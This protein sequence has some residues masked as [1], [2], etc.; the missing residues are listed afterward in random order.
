MQIESY[1]YSCSSQFIDSIS[2][3]LHVELHEVISNLPKRNT[4]SEINQDLFWL[5]TSQGWSLK[6]YSIRTLRH[7]ILGFV[8]AGVNTKPLDMFRPSCWRVMNGVHPSI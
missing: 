1:Y 2:P 4:Q 6:G 5:L 8:G 3:T 7:L